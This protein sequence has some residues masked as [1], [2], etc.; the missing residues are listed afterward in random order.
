MM[1]CLLTKYAWNGNVVKP[2]PPTH[3]RLN[4]TREKLHAPDVS[5][6]DPGN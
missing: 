3:R 1:L 4:E 5:V 2:N 6:S